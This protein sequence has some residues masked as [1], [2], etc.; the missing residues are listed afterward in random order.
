MSTKRP[1]RVQERIS[2]HRDYVAGLIDRFDRL[3]EAAIAAPEK[4]VIRRPVLSPT[5]R[6]ILADLHHLLLE[7]QSFAYR[8]ALETLSQDRKPAPTGQRKDEKWKNPP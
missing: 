2:F 3:E 6:Q 8:E 1:L 7:I 4:G 5:D